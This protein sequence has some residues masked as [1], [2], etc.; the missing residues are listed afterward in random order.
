MRNQLKRRK[1]V[2]TDD[3]F[4]LKR[5]AIIILIVIAIVAFA[6]GLLYSTT[7]E[8]GYAPRNWNPNTTPRGM[9]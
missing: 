5:K 9:P 3:P 4:A 2:E 7:R 6:L 8:D 1:K